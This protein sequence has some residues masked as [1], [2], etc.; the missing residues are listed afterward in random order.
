MGPSGDATKPSGPPLARSLPIRK[1]SRNA[2]SNLRSLYRMSAQNMRAAQ[3]GHDPS[4]LDHKALPTSPQLPPTPPNAVNGDLPTPAEEN[5]SDTAIFRSALVTPINQHNPPTPDNTP[6]QDRK[7]LV[8]RPWLGP[9]TSFTS[10]LAESFTTAQEDFTSDP[11]SD[12]Q[13]KTPE[14]TFEWPLTSI[15]KFGGHLRQKSLSR[16]PL[17]NDYSDLHQISHTPEH[18]EHGH[19]QYPSIPDPA[20]PSDSETEGNPTDTSTPRSR[21][22]RSDHMLPPHNG[23]H[24]G[25]EEKTSSPE[26]QSTELPPSS[27]L[28]NRLLEAQSQ[29]PSASTEK[30]A[31]IIGW[32]DSV[33]FGRSDRQT[34][35]VVD[36]E[37]DYRRFSRTS[38]TS[39]VE[40]YVFEQSP[41]P[42]RTTTLR[43]MNKH[44]S[45]RSVSSPLP[46]SKR[47]S[48]NSWTESPH[49]LIHKKARLSNQNR[50]SAGSEISRSHSLAS[51]TILPKTEVIHVAVIPERSSSLSSSRRNS[52]N[53]P[54]PSS[55]SGKS[56]SRKPSDQPPSSWQHKRAFSEA[57]ERGRQQHQAPVVPPRSSSL[58]APTSKA[59]SCANSITSSHFRVQRQRAEKDLRRTLDRMESDMLLQK[60]PR[61][62]SEQ[63]Q[64]TAGEPLSRN[65]PHDLRS[66]SMGHNAPWSD[67]IPHRSVASPLLDDDGNQN[68]LGLVMPGTTEW[69]SMRPSSILDTPFSQPSFQSASPELSEAHAINYFAHNN[70]S[71]QLIEPFPVHESKAVLEVQ[72]AGLSH[73]EV[74]SP[75]R[76]PR[77]PPEPPQFHVVP[78]TPADELDPRLGLEDHLPPGRGNSVRR[79]TSSRGR[80]E[81]FITALSRNLSVKN[82]R[83]R[84]AGQDLNGELHPFWRPR[85]FWDDVDNSRPESDEA[86][87]GGIIKN[88]LGL[89]QERTV[90]TGPA[91]LIRRISERRQQRRRVARQSSHSSLAKLRAGRHL[92][93]SAPN[94]MRLHFVGIR[95]I[96]DWMLQAK[97]RKEEEKREKR[98]AELRKSIGANVISQGDSRFPT[99]NLDEFGGTRFP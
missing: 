81:S 91:S 94:A 8:V 43:H 7:P 32:N 4:Q 55:E 95:N 14:A 28:R 97:R 98:R 96:Q 66:H 86:R 56:Q 26:M 67:S 93:R 23:Q 52:F 80:S 69:A 2:S 46:A 51:T 59:T 99:S 74:D 82:P 42:K 44:E 33:H 34:R 29:T 18:Y 84:K 75:L 12:Q 78:P 41:L 5:A 77:R 85:A 58:S 70:H 38:T 89:P 40:A 11:G 57:L 88:S 47:G 9:Q 6:P 53:R 60:L 30:F 3:V 63:A 36:H 65:G 13:S 31:N 22:G 25:D 72:R 92:H 1:D 54:S 15:A 27:G 10:T 16:S 76:N 61:W 19:T 21:S 37:D 90:V 39:T 64:P 68:T 62:T 73:S 17:M 83:N 24:R 87:N 45:L 48:L 79:P 20:V 35:V 71:L 50:W 49:P